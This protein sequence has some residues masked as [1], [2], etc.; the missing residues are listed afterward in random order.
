MYVK[1]EKNGDTKLCGVIN[2]PKGWDAIQG[3]LERLQQWTQKPHEAKYEVLHLCC[4][5]PQYQHM[6]GDVRIE[7]SHTE[8]TW[9]YWWM[10]N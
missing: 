4:G 5:N 2:T 7:H 10:A 3:N 9:G 1:L 6:L 8:G